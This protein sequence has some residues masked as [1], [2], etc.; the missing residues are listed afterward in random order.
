[1]CQRVMIAIAI[2]CNPRLLIADE[3]TTGLDV[4][5]QKATMDLIFELTREQHLSVILITHDLGLAASY[6]DRITVMQKGKVIE[7]APVERLFT[8]PQHEYTKS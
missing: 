5:T 8:Q 7:S 3:P 4:T 1:M 6:C 2:A